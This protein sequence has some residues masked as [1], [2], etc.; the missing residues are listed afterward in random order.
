MVFLKH[1]FRTLGLYFFSGLEHGNNDKKTTHET[2]VRTIFFGVLYNWKPSSSYKL[3]WSQ[4][5]YNVNWMTHKLI[6]TYINLVWIVTQG[7][8]G[9][10]SSTCCHFSTPSF[11]EP[12]VSFL[13]GQTSEKAA[14]ETRAQVSNPVERQARRLGH[15]FVLQQP[16]QQLSP[17]TFLWN[18]SL[19]GS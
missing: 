1:I 6:I 4:V 7:L 9:L 5:I 13:I 11:I 10:D 12:K 15:Q 8:P 19:V 3:K 14:P 2:R 17:S 18:V 16:Q